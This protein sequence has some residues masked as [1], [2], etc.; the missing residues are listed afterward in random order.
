MSM[1]KQVGSGPVS[2][3]AAQSLAFKLLHRLVDVYSRAIH[4]KLTTSELDSLVI[5][6]VTNSQYSRLPV[7]WRGYIDGQHA[8]R[9]Q[10]L[11]DQHAIWLLSID[12]QLLTK[13]EEKELHQR[14]IA[15]GKNQKP[16]Y[17]SPI[18]RVD[19][20]LCR[21]VWADE[22]GNPLKDRPFDLRFRS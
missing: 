3:R 16:D 10:Q 20:A 6:E 5:H 15:E 19:A 17:L 9:W 18:S 4:F 8:L 22:D 14:E 2:G 12:G 13:Q 11:W 7:Y 21:H 1:S